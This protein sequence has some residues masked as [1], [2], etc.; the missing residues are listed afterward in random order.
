MLRVEGA[1]SKIEIWNADKTQ[2]FDLAQPLTP[3]SQDTILWIKG[4]QA[5]SSLRDITLVLTHSETGFQDRIK[6]TVYDADLD[7]YSGQGGPLAPETDQDADG[8]EDEEDIGAFTVANLND[9]NGDGYA[10]SD[11]SHRPVPLLPREYGRVVQKCV[12]PT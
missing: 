5:S 9:T 10:D 4:V 7:I 8:I 11:D 6:L 3:S 12:Q 1:A 2:L